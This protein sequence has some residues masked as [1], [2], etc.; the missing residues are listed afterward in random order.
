[1]IFVDLVLMFSDIDMIKFDVPVMCLLCVF[2]A[3]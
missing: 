1:M 2:T 3:F